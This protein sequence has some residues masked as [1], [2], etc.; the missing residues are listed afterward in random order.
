MN[1]ENKTTVLNI[2]SQAWYT[3]GE[4]AAVLSANSGRPIR[5][6]YVSK[7]GWLDKVRTKKIHARLTLYYRPDIDA[8]KVEA[9]GVK[10]GEAQKA[11]SVARKKKEVNDAA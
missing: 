5:T 3:A 11:K 10:S 6:D 8:Y 7:L 2:D 9:R 1:K 4:A